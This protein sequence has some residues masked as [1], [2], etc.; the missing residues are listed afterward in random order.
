LSVTLPDAT[1]RRRASLLAL[2][3]KNRLYDAQFGGGLTNHLPMAL[4][5]LHGMGASES[6]LCAYFEGY[7]PRLNS[8]PAAAL[9]ITQASWSSALG[10]HRRYSDH[11]AF[12][13]DNVVQQG[14]ELLL[15]TYLP[16]L[17]E[18]VAGGAFHGVIR[19]AY[20]VEADDPLEVAAALAYFSDV[21]LPVG[22]ATDRVGASEPLE[23]MR[24]MRLS[25][26]LSRR[27]REGS[28]IFDRLQEIAS[29]PAFLEFISGVSCRD[30][31][32]QQLARAA[33][34]SYAS[35]DDFT[36]LHVVTGC[37]ALRVLSPYLGVGQI[38]RFALP[39]ICAAYLSVGTPAFHEPR[40]A[41]RADD[42]APDWTDIFSCALESSD[43][44]VIKLVYTCHQ[45]NHAY[46]SP[47]YRSAAAAK[48]GLGLLG[49]TVARERA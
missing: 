22:A 8:K 11:L 6:R 12:F 34:L 2:L 15:R 36:L 29:E 30:V 9:P 3:E 25:P 35:T 5:A 18:G 39:A 19:L 20:A 45:E 42:S 32:L 41:D 17:L 48:V 7:K 37:H 31:T 40:G 14:H 13:E 44:H 47:L 1:Q 24:Q 28:L 23:V 27:V 21:F 46:G 26:T 33:I 4:V 16:A 10:T 43:E 49:R 38:P